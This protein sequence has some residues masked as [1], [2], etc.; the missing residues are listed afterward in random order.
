VILAL[1]VAGLIAQAATDSG[2][3]TIYKLQHA[4]GAETWSL[5]A[6]DAGRTLSTHWAFRYIGSDVRLDVTLE[7]ASD[8]TPRRL[9]AHGQTSTL[10]DVDLSVTL[11][12]DSATIVNRGARSVV[13][14]VQPAFPIFHYPPVALEEALF[15]SRTTRLLPG[16]LVT[17]EYRGRDTL[18]LHRYSVK[19]LLWGRQTMWA[20][21]DKRIVAVVNG[22]AE[23][24]RSVGVRDGNANG[25]G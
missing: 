1:G 16:G 15:R 9:E 18:G 2:R 11:G 19:G 21:I 25:R 23:L 14:Y 17:F 4:V 22:D 10:T 7:S 12:A 24:E 8:G 3:F 20:T 13:R 6:T 5:M